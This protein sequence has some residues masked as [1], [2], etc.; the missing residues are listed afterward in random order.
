[1]RPSDAHLDTIVALA[2]PAGRSAIALVRLSG[3]EAPRMLR[4]LAPGL[5]AAERLRPRRPYLAALREGG[6]DGEPI[7]SALVTFFA[8]PASATG[9]DV[10]ELSIHGSPAVVERVLQAAIAAGA[11]PARPGPAI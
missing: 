4:A 6:A 1:M 2:T 8:A 10:A 11:R 7:D 3:P 5:P 9:E